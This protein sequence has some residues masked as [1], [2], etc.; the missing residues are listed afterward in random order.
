MILNID[1]KKRRISLGIKQCK[2]NPWK[3]FLNIKKIKCCIKV[4][5]KSITDFGIF[6]GLF[7]GIDGLIHLSDISWNLL[8]KKS[9]IKYKKGDLIR[10]IIL[11]VD[12][13]RERI[14]LGIKQ[15]NIDNFNKFLTIYKKNNFIYCKCLSISKKKIKINLGNK[16]IGYLNNNLN[17]I[18]FIKFKIKKL[19]KLNFIK[20][21]SKRILILSLI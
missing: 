10:S 18:N 15:L 9:T 20:I 3:N 14:S 2:I 19:I 13:K 7:N 1:M 12:V 5:V 8:N 11:Q 16:L 6:V 4:V 17:S 21:R